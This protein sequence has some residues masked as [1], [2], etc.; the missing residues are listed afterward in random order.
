[1]AGSVEWQ[2]LDETA[3]A[4]D[5]VTQEDVVGLEDS[6]CVAFERDELIPVIGT[7]G[8]LHRDVA[9]IVGPTVG[10]VPAA[11]VKEDGISWF[12]L[13]RRRRKI[14]PVDAERV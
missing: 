6:G 1:M 4:P 5:F 7:G 13:E 3:D 9:S 14:G 10:G 8:E 11:V 12:N 2:V